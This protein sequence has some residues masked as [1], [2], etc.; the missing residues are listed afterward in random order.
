MIQFTPQQ[1]AQIK[2]RV[3]PQQIASLIA[4]NAVVL[5]NDVLV[6]PDGRATWQP[7][8]LLPRAWR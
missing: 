5:E 6:P 7:L 2:Q 4:D 3:S 8:L 1:M